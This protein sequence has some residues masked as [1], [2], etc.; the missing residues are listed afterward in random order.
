MHISNFA[1]QFR[2]AS[3]EIMQNDTICDPLLRGNMVLPPIG[4]N[5]VEFFRRCQCAY[6]FIICGQQNWQRQP[7]NLVDIAISA[8]SLQHSHGKTTPYNKPYFSL[9]VSDHPT[10]ISQNITETQPRPSQN[11]SPRLPTPIIDRRSTPEHMRGYISLPVINRHHSYIQEN[12]NHAEAE[13]EGSN[14]GK[15]IRGGNH[16]QST[17][18]IN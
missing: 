14:I 16:K 12:N 7:H 17:I 5:F 8:L 15:S 13:E 4:I 9:F 2:L 11:H 3:K 1:A 10:S 18:V 6:V